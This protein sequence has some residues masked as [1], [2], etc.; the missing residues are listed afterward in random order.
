MS[1]NLGGKYILTANIDCSATSTWNSGQGFNPIG[2]FTGILDGNGRKIIGLTINRSEGSDLGMFSSTSM[3]NIYNVHLTELKIFGKTYV[4]GLVGT[5]E[6]STIHKSSSS[7]TISADNRVGGIVGRLKSNS[8]LLE[9]YS[10]A[11]VTASY[12]VA[13]GLVGTNVEGSLIN[14]SYSTGNVIVLGNS[15]G[16]LVGEQ[17]GPPLSTTLSNS[18]S[19][20]RVIPGRPALG[21]IAGYG[22]ISSKFKSVY[23]NADT[24]PLDMCGNADSGCFG[25]EAKSTAEMKSYF[26]FSS[27]DFTNVWMMPTNDYPHLKWEGLTPMIYCSD[28]DGDGWN[29][30]AGGLCGPFADCDESNPN[31]N[32]GETEICSN[33]IDD[34]CNNLIDCSDDCSSTP[35]CGSFGTCSVSWQN[36]SS[37]SGANNDVANSIALD[38]SGNVYVG[39]YYTISG[40]K[41]WRI[42]SFNPF[43]GNLIYELND[44]IATTSEIKAI[45]IDQTTNALYALG[46]G[47]NLAG[48]NTQE[49]WRLMKINAATGAKIWDTNFSRDPS[50][51]GED[52]PS[53]IAL[54]SSGEIYAAGSSKR[55]SDER[56][57]W[58]ALKINPSNG[59]QI[60]SRYFSSATYKGKTINSIAVDSARSFVYLAGDT[61]SWWRVEQLDSANGQTILYKA[62]AD[63]APNSPSS[64][65]LDNSGNLYVAGYGSNLVKSSSSGDWQI[66]KLNP[67]L[68]ITWK[69]KFSSPGTNDDRA[70]SIALDPANNAIYVAGYGAHLTSSSSWNDLG[71]IKLNSVYGNTLWS[72]NFSSSGTQTDQANSIAFDTINH[73]L[74]V[75]GYGFN[76]LG[77]TTQDWWTVKFDCTTV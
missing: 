70:T 63:N 47:S 75:A 14:N 28:P 18:Y 67:A 27:W 39:G 11:N 40:V 71:I 43:N 73:K 64:L 37:S 15:A 31:R 36:K 51:W 48:T 52:I 16:G 3:A 32:P 21:G 13:G 65:A 10:A 62:I 74:Y 60:W 26:T 44:S 57:Y 9:C 1:N 23:W 59:S 69:A 53:S 41:R 22:D 20:G 77:S 8:K 5:S 24:S 76:L 29:V 58:W 42:K 19:I 35:F 33:S 54:D 55:K 7:G 72:K 66:I 2:P 68:G 25:G 56:I 12:I 49:D 34:N 38:S 17:F 6:Q 50:Y 61:P 46:Y 30:T 4:G 45:T